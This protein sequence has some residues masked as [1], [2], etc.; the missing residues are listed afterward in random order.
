MNKGVNMENKSV[1]SLNIVS[2][3]F[4]SI[5]F[6]LAIDSLIYAIVLEAG[7][8]LQEQWNLNQVIA[9]YW[10]IFA[11]F[12]CIC[13]VKTYN[14]ITKDKLKWTS[15]IL[16][17]GAFIAL[18]VFTIISGINLNY[19]VS[20]NELVKVLSLGA[21]I[22]FLVMLIM[23]TVLLVVDIVKGALVRKNMKATPSKNQTEDKPKKKT[24]LLITSALIFM[25]SFA[26]MIAFP[27][28][29]TP[30]LN[31]EVNMERVNDSVEVE[32]VNN[33]D[34]DIGGRFYWSHLSR[35]ITQLNSRDVDVDKGESTSFTL[36][37][38]YVENFEFKSLSFSAPGLTTTY[39]LG[40]A[41]IPVVL[42]SGSIFITTFIN[43]SKKQ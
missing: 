15:Y 5:L 24:W 12:I 8:S 43:K 42:A 23:C 33:S 34:Y 25:A 28:V 20:D 37:Y 18:F 14:F 38:A 31:I 27:V 9:F 3:V 39:A 26:I 1:K 29:F 16:L 30:T 2:I 19:P 10:T 4:T 6:L 36:I 40:Y 7:Y 11:F 32:I 13:A 22:N 17:G 41:M 21:F 35:N